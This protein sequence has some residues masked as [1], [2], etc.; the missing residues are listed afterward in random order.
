MANVFKKITATLQPNTNT[1][2]FTDELINNNSVIELYCDD[3]DVFPVSVIQSGEHSIR[4]EYSDHETSVGIAITINNVITFEP[5]DDTDVLISISDL[6]TNKQDKLTSGQNITIE[7]NVI[8]ASSGVSELNEL[9]DVL[10]TSPEDGLPLVYDDN[11]G[12]WLQD[13]IKSDNVVYSGTKH[14]S[15]A[16]TN[17]IDDLTESIES[18]TTD[19]T[20]NYEELTTT[21]NDNYIALSS[22][23]DSNYSV[24]SENKQDVLT[25]GQNITIENNVISASGGGGGN[26]N[27]YSLNETVIGEFLGKTLYRKVYFISTAG[28][29][30]GTSKTDVN[31]YVTNRD[32]IETI[33]TATLIRPT[34]VNAVG[35]FTSQGAAYIESG[36]IKLY[37][38]STSTN[39]MTHFLLEYTKKGDN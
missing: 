4:V 13:T 17:I 39:N 14:V 21:I 38:G 31:Q 20:E 16:I 15:S 6:E 28:I 24:L 19:I 22:T 29:S 23:I 12:V 34:G 26:S 8:S 2:I 35:N 27:I 3:N 37:S 18:N 11:H 9:N 7:N 32:E 5:Y 36:V 25:A 33:V 30:I 10:V 1:H